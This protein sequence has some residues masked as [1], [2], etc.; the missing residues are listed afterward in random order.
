MFLMDAS[1]ECPPESFIMLWSTNY[2]KGKSES[3]VASF[4]KIFSSKSFLP[5]LQ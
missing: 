2:M 5:L 3:T 1:S 4:F